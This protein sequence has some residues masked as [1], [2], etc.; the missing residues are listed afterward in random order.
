MIFFVLFSW[1]FG[2]CCS[3]YRYV[4]FLI[5]ILI[6]AHNMAIKCKIAGVKFEDLK[7]DQFHQGLI[8]AAAIGLQ[9]YGLT[10]WLAQP[11][12]SANPID[13]FATRRKRKSGPSKLTGGIATGLLPT[14]GHSQ[15]PNSNTSLQDS[16]WIRT[17]RL[18][19]SYTWL[20]MRIGTSPAGFSLWP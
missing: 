5:A 9:V 17:E 10:G 14:L 20:A 19:H 12:D 4:Q 15:R 18:L 16:R 2:R 6:S 13:H 8:V 3:M 7:A 1:H 11:A